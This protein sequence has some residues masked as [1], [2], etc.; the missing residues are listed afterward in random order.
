[1]YLILRRV[2]NSYLCIYLFATVFSSNLV[3]DVAVFKLCALI[4]TTYNI[5]FVC[6]FVVLALFVILTIMMLCKQIIV[7]YAIS[8]DKALMGQPSFHTNCSNELRLGLLQ[9]DL[10]PCLYEI[11]WG[12]SWPQS[13]CHSILQFL[14]PCCT[15]AQS[16][17]W[18]SSHI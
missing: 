14:V 13:S 11:P 12:D 7:L 16:W 15:V 8:N 5:G 9:G 2:T 1:M 4:M 17:G 18:I 6:H 10:Y 3:D